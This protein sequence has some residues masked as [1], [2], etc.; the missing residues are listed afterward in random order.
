M[1]QKLRY[2]LALH[3]ALLESLCMIYH[4]FFSDRHILFITRFRCFSGEIL[5]LKLC[6]RIK[7]KFI[8][9]LYYSKLLY[10]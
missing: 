7:R 5:Q 4:D 10:N 8:K 6:S 2:Y 1:F 3:N 9:N